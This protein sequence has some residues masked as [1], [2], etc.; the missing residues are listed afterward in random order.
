MSLRPGKN[1]QETT[2]KQPKTP[3]QPNKKQKPGH[4]RDSSGS[5]KGE[6]ERRS[7]ETE[8]G[9]QI[10]Q[11]SLSAHVQVQFERLTCLLSCMHLY[12]CASSHARSRDGLYAQAM[13]DGCTHSEVS[14]GIGIRTG[15]VSNGVTGMRTK[16]SRAVNGTSLRAVRPTW[17]LLCRRFKGDHELIVGRGP[18][19]CAA[20]QGKC[21]QRSPPPQ[22]EG[23]ER[24]GN[25]APVTLKQLCK[26]MAH[27]GT[28]GCQEVAT[29][30]FQIAKFSQ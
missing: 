22:R 6:T 25:P 17:V 18:L 14:R 15:K 19:G 11:K 26:R 12:S 23:R 10:M 3:K 7:G 4:P 27:E 30:G 29:S 9:R 1:K 13:R 8:V 20:Y 16:P 21:M 5:C 28:R 24:K 2:T